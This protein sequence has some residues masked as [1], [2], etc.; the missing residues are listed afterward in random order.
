M[1][2]ASIVNKVKTDLRISHTAL[3]GDISDSI[4]ACLA[5]LRICG[6]TLPDEEDPA[7]L[8]LIKLWS[9]A[10]YTDDTAKQEVYMARYNAMKATLMMASGYGDLP[11]D[12]GDANG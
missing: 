1:T 8:N 12:G 6:V 5:D 4:E 10:A 9:R 2:R 11:D 3:D 7:I